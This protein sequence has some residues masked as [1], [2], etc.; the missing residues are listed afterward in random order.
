MVLKHVDR[1]RLGGP[2]SRRP[3]FDLY[4]VL[5]LQWFQRCSAGVMMYVPESS[6]G[7]MGVTM[8]EAWMV[9]GNGSC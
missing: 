9:E 7:V 3:V 2:E 6:S 1:K 4:D 8:F 5:R